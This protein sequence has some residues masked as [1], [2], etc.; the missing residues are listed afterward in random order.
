MPALWRLR[1][2]DGKFE[3]SLGNIARPYLIKKKRKKKERQGYSKTGWTGGSR[4][5]DKDHNPVGQITG[6]RAPGR[7]QRWLLCPILS[8][9]GL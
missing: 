2:E 3:G 5:R 9:S 1:Q 7:N 8:G 4:G 6:A